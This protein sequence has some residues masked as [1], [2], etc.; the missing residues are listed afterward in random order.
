[1]KKIPNDLIEIYKNKILNIHPS[2]LPKYG[3]KGF[4][5]MKVHNAVFNSNEKI[6]GVTVHYVNEEYDKG[7]VL[8]QEKIDITDCS[9]PKQIAKKVLKLEHEIFPKA[10]IK[11]LKNINKYEKN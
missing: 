3:G 5:G 2:L 9:N 1:M 6:S 11:H 8:L 4:Y 10:I 7:P